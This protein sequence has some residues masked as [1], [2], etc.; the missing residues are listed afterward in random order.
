MKNY[1]KRKKGGELQRPLWKKSG[2]AK[3]SKKNSNTNFDCLLHGS[4]MT[5]DMN[6]CTALKREA[7]KHKEGAKAKYV[8]KKINNNGQEIHTLIEFATKAMNDAKAGKKRKTKNKVN[9]F[10]HLMVSK[11]KNNS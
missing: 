4:N 2:K 5:H 3:A 8:P 11:M 7:E 6:N 1:L 9:Y 10:E